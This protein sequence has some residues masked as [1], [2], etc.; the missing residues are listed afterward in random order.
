MLVNLFKTISKTCNNVFE[1]LSLF[2]TEQENKLLREVVIPRKQEWLNMYAAN[3]WIDQNPPV[4]SAY[5]NISYNE[6]QSIKTL[7]E[8]R[9][10]SIKIYEA[11][12]YKKIL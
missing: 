2:L 4:D 5:H 6:I 8:Y 10:I 7:E 1:D 9:R 3:G 11:M 12:G